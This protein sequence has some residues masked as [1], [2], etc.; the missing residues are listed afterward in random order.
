M[1]S[2]GKPYRPR[3]SPFVRVA[4][5]WLFDPRHDTDGL[6]LELLAPI[7]RPNNPD[8]A[9]RHIMRARYGAQTSP[10]WVEFTARASAESWV[11]AH[12]PYLLP[13]LPAPENRHAVAVAWHWP[14]QRPTSAAN[15]LKPRPLARANPLITTADGGAV[16]AGGTLAARAS[17]A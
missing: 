16:A 3:M 17:S 5:A 13:A 10:L 6:T 11:R 12:F 2:A 7:A 15:V 14:A 1:T 4:H 9:P 8:A